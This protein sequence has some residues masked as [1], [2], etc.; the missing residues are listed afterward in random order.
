MQNKYNKQLERAFNKSIE[1][2]G[3]FFTPSL[4]AIDKPSY[5]T[6]EIKKII[7]DDL[8]D[9]VIKRSS[10]LAGKCYILVREASYVLHDN[11]IKHSL[12]IGN[13]KVNGK[14]YFTTTLESLTKE[15][16][17]GYIPFEPAN[18]HAW[19]TLDSGQ[20][21][22]LSILASIANKNKEK[23]LSVFD[24]ILVSKNDTPSKLEHIPMFTGFGYHFKVVTNQNIDSRF[25]VYLQWFYEFTHK[26]HYIKRGA[27]H[28]KNRTRKVGQRTER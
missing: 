4:T 27:T 14:P 23:E 10:A 16:E 8:L 20:I 13:V 2:F 1:I 28:D 12:T 3:E 5:N 7:S 15:V 9:G 26:F 19:L 24:A 17:N 18:A 25:D 21:L 22:D 11:G 6:D